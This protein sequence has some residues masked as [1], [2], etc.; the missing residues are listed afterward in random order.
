MV[1]DFLEITSLYR[2]V[3]QGCMEHLEFLVTNGQDLCKYQDDHGRTPLH[4]AVLQEQ[5]HLIEYLAQHKCQINATD[6][7]GD[8]PLHLSMSI[9]NRTVTQKLLEYISSPPHITTQ[10]NFTF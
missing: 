3:S 1:L 7:N 2:A 10:S 9:Q 6:K 4:I 8:T 5:A